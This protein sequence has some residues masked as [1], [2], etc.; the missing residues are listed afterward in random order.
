MTELEY[1]VED[2]VATLRL[3]RPERKNSF[4]YPMI[5]RWAEVLREAQRDAAVRCVVLTGSGDS[6]CAGVDLN[7][8]DEVPNEPAARMEVYTRRIHEVHR[9][10][11]ALEKPLLAAVNGVAVGAGM[12]LALMCDVRWAAESARFAEGYV[13]VG[14]I[15]G[16]GGCFTLPRLVG[17]ARALELMWTGDFVD[18]RQAFELGIVTRVLPDDELAGAVSA[19]ARRL[20][21]APPLAI[22]S[23]KRITYRSLGLDIHA[24]LSLAAAESAVIQSTADYKE[25][26]AAF[27]E[28]RPGR[29]VGA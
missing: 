27:R 17:T 22:Q 19:F 9:A 26:L 6:F 12:D 16:A 15:P 21:A 2:G 4:T 20:A 24:S 18:A 14:L 8:K 11:T 25:C 3:N 5:D 10:I 7:A 28:K 1:G 29:Y 13:K 23:I